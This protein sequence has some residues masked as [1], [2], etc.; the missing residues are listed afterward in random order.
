MAAVPKT[1]QER[2]LQS[3]DR[4]VVTVVSVKQIGPSTTCLQASL[5]SKNAISEGRTVTT[6]STLKTTVAS[7]SRPIDC[8]GAKQQ[9]ASVSPGRSVIHLQG[10]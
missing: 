4:S 1:K 6:T 9:S 3:P 2:G 7:S 5:M 10:T 8:P